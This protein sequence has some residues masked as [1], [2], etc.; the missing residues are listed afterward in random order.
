LTTVAGVCWCGEGLDSSVHPEYGCCRACGT[1]VARAIPDPKA[2][3][4]FIGLN[5][6]SRDRAGLE[7]T[8]LTGAIFSYHMF[9]ICRRKDDATPGL[10]WRDRLK[11]ALPH[12]RKTTRAERHGAREQRR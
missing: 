2:L 5:P 4:S 7:V 6:Y 1:Q 10:R 8:A 9:I 12:R 11:A 3:K